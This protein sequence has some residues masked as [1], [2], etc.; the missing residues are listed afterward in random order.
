MAQRLISDGPTAA[1]LRKVEGP[2][3]P[4]S[5]LGGKQ[6]TLRAET[7][8]DPMACRRQAS[9]AV[10]CVEARRIRVLHVLWSLNRG[11]IETWLKQVLSKIDRGRFE[12]DF[13]VHTDRSCAYE[14]DVR[15]HGAKILRCPHPLR[16]LSYARDFFRIL[17][18]NGPYQIVHA[19][20]HFYSGFVLRLARLAGV[21]VR[22]AHSHSDKRPTQGE[23]AP[24]QK[25]Y[26]LA[27]RRWIERHAMAGLA[28][29][30][31]AASDL[32]GTRWAEA[33][34]WRVLHYGIDLG[35]FLDGRRNARLREEFGIPADAKVVG[36]VGRFVPQKNHMFL[37]EALAHAMARDRNLWALLVGDGP[38]RDPAQRRA[39]ALGIDDRVVFAGERGDVAELM[40]GAMDVFVFPSLFEG[41]GIVLLE[42]QA[43]GL[44]C[45]ISDV[46]PHEV[47]AVPGLLE[48]IPLSRGVEEWAEAILAA[49][50][51]PR[52]VDQRTAV[53]TLQGSSFDLEVCVRTLERF[54]TDCVRSAS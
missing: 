32:F 41:L 5:G 52:P 21:P 23:A 51:R 38:L 33:G 39:R 37:L 44:P 7:F 47:E 24:Y 28:A 25:L 20:T 13:L 12:M 9:G 10:V 2:A 45:V 26:R 29:S 36:H 22:I 17:R 34:P 18:E 4:G 49:A 48:R 15:A 43:A 30:R 27:M 1:A 16:P 46:V 11:G 40:L 3:D 35:P 53:R 50:R 31:E 42:S 54:Y 19:H 14:A 8:R 6:P